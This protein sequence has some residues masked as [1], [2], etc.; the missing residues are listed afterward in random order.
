MTSI[1]DKEKA[2]LLDWKKRF[3]IIHGIVRGLLYLHHDSRLKII[4]RDLKAS[5]VLLDSNLNPKI[6]D[7]G[8]AKIFGGD[9]DE[10]KT[11]R[12]VGTYGYMSPEYAMDGLFS[13]KSDVF[14]FGIL[15]LE[16]ISGRK[17]TS[18]Y[19]ESSLNLIGHVWD[20][21]KQDKALT[22]VDSSLRESFNAR[23][24]LL[25]IHVGILCVQELASDRPT[26]TD[27]AFMLSKHNT[28][29]P[30]P[31]RPAFIFRQM[32]YGRDLPS[33]SASGGIGSVD[34]DTITIPHAR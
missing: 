34:D 33:A 17:N 2:N 14:S 16:I 6:S 22:I 15:V 8:L 24:V 25:C 4:H 26:M 19:K 29:L 31:N 18:F 27:I 20:F 32:N 21:W 13:V 10:A 9:E 5:N 7:F 1:L 12:V 28:I 3:Q 30:S 11:R 23:E